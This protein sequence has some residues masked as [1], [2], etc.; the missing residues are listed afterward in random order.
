M[1]YKTNTPNY[2]T[3]NVVNFSDF[4]DSID[5][6]KE[7][8]KDLKRGIKPNTQDSQK[9]TRNKK[10][11]YNRVT[12]KID[13]LSRDE[14][15]DKIDSIDES[16]TDVNI[17]SMSRFLDDYHKKNNSFKKRGMDEG[18]KI[19][20]DSKTI[21]DAIVGINKKIEELKRKDKEFMP[22]SQ[23]EDMIA[24]L[25]DLIKNLEPKIG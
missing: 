25:Y 20:S 2:R 10:S 21:E 17:A 14:I 9:F 16:A 1:T 23:K 12:K 8:L 7:E 24:G 5:S 6:E 18:I 13:D 19:L 3:K 11:K 15:V 4:I 22:D